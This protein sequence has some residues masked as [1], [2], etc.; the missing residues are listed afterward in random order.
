MCDAVFNINSACIKPNRPRGRDG[1]PRVFRREDSLAARPHDEFSL[2][3]LQ[4]FVM[5]K[6]AVAKLARMLLYVVVFA[7]SL[8]VGTAISAVLMKAV[9]L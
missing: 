7:L 2:I 9:E 8:V 1:K 3:F 5:V 6:S 4:E